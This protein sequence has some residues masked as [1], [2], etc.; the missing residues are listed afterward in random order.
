MLFALHG[1]VFREAL[2][3]KA[4]THNYDVDEHILSFPLKTSFKMT[5]KLSLRSE[6]FFNCSDYVEENK[7]LKRE[8]EVLRQ[9]RDTLKK[10]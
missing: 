5:K 9:E 1:T 4:S 3:L 7:K 10:R 8:V 2:A 6:S